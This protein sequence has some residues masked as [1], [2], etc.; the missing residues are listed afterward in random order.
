MINNT[1]A[2]VANLARYYGIDLNVSAMKKTASLRKVCFEKLAKQNGLKVKKVFCKGAKLPNDLHFPIVAELE[3]AE[4]NYQRSHC[5]ILKRKKDKVHIITEEGRKVLDL[6]AFENIFSGTFYLIS[7]KKDFAN[8]KDSVKDLASFF[9]LLK[10]EKK[11]VAKIF[12]A[13][14]MLCL[15]GVLTAF[16]FRFLIDEVFVAGLENMLNVFSFA[17][18]II[19]SFQ[20]LLS[21]ARNQLL[22]FLGHKIDASI[23]TEYFSHIFKLPMKF[24]SKIKTGEII[25]RMYDGRTIR[26]LIS[27]TFLSVS[28]DAVMLVFGS[29]FL[30]LFASKLLFISIISVIIGAFVAKIFA[31]PYRLKML[32]RAKSEAIKQSYLVE[33]ISGIETIKASAAIDYACEKSEEKIID[34]IKKNLNIKTVTNLQNTIQYFVQQLGTLF[35]YYFGGR[36]IINGEMTLGQLISFVILSQYFIGPLFRFLT[37]QPTLQEAKTAARRLLEIF[38]ERQEETEGAKIDEG[39]LYGDIEFNNVNFSYGSGKAETLRNIN[40]K[41]KSGDKVAFVG[42][43]GSGKSTVAKLLMKFQNIDSGEILID[44]KNISDYSVDYIRNN[45]GYV[46]QDSI[47]FS[48]TIAENIMLGN[49]HANFDDVFKASILSKAD[50]FIRHLDERYET[51]VGERGASLSGGERQRLAIARCILKNPAMF[52]LDESSSALDNMLE[53]AVLNSIKNVTKNKTLIMISHKLSSIKDFD[54]IFVLDKGQIIESGTHSELLE[55]K[56]KYSDLWFTQNL[57]VMH[58]KTA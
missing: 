38:N 19:I 1:I 42:E 54:K 23:V 50:S 3:S 46:P 20:C 48:G 26:N 17:F 32:E 12:L 9:F 33:F 51:Q 21:F 55:A 2:C 18:F 29:I 34:A 16:Y 58:E 11:N 39:F 7:P 52:I 53:S 49:R 45:I 40:L 22:N 13:S 24:F 41:I 14:L 8:T 6:L 47:L 30:F 36:A 27:T 5:L 56:G 31:K 10:A 28:I 4:H 43:S 37:L 15:F 25:S 57:E 35:I 44:G